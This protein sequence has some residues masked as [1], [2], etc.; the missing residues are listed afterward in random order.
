MF[1]F[2]DHLLL[3]AFGLAVMSAVGYITVHKLWDELPPGIQ[4]L[5]NLFMA[6]LQS[7][8]KV[9]IGP[10]ELLQRVNVSVSSPSMTPTLPP[11]SPKVQKQ[12]EGG[13]TMTKL[14]ATPENLQE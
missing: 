2:L 7:S 10:F 8:S 12:V 14:L 3:Y 11:E 1:E 4:A 5:A 6:I 9:I 13:R